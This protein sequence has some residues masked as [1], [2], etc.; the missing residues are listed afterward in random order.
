[1]VRAYEMVIVL[2]PELEEA[3]RGKIIDEVKGIIGKFKGTIGGIDEWGKKT[4]AYPINKLKEGY[5][6]L[7]EYTLSPEGLKE[8]DRK[9]KINEKVIRFQALRAAQSKKKKQICDDTETEKIEETETS[10]V[11][12][13]GEGDD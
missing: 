11:N 8:V 13:T 2:H 10:D 12:Q 6:I 5:Y 4:L 3:D 1:M 9:L 7:M